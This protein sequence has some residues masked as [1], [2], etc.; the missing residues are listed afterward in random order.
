[1]NAF[2]PFLFED[3]PWSSAGVFDATLQKLRARNISIATLQ[4]LHDVDTQEQLIAW[5]NSKMCS[6]A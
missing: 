1:M 6:V 3:I 5:E 4:A 2:Y